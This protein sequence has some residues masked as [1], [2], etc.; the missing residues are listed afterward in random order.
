MVH[1]FGDINDAASDIF[2]IKSGFAAYLAGD[3]SYTDLSPYFKE[4][5]IEADDEN[6]L[7]W[8]RE[9]GQNIAIAYKFGEKDIFNDSI[10]GDI[11]EYFCI[12][13]NAELSDMTKTVIK[14]L[15][16]GN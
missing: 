9:N 8:Q 1:L 14:D 4:L 10:S 6:V 16:N 5:N 15:I 11:P 13:E 7:W 3:G 2:I 12:P